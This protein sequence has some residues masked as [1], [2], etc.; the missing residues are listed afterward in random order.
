MPIEKIQMFKPNT[1]YA[2]LPEYKV[3]RFYTADYYFLQMP[4]YVL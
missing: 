1:L 4:F 3:W 2:F